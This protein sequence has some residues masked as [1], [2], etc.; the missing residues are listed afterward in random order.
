MFCIPNNVKSTCT[1]Q[2]YK[3]HIWL[4]YFIILTLLDLWA[5][6]LLLSIWSHPILCL[7]YTQKCWILS[8]Y[9]LPVPCYHFFSRFI[10]AKFTYKVIHQFK[11][12]SS[13]LTNVY[14][15]VTTTGVPSRNVQPEAATDLLPAPKRFAFSRM[16]NI[17]GI[18]FYVLFFIW[19]V[20]IMLFRI[21]HVVAC[22]HTC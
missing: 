2:Q 18:I 21:I 11:M 13:S 9:P 16:S 12:Q 14:T 6:S 10:E 3:V 1:L 5:W 20:S 22:C 19:L 4:K 15:I 8:F 7:K 17:S